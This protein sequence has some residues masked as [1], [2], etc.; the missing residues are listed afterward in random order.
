MSK[1]G[2]KS[3]VKKIYRYCRVKA[4]ILKKNCKHSVVNNDLRN[5]YKFNELSEFEILRETEKAVLI[6]A[7]GEIWIP[8]SA[9][10]EIFESK[11]DNIHRKSSIEWKQM[12]FTIEGLTNE[13]INE[14]IV[15]LTIEIKEMSKTIDIDEI[16]KSKEYKYLNFLKSRI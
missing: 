8:K 15:K 6:N 4:W 2:I 16:L 10:V 7:N 14:K 5:G 3:D 1:L 12:Y 9:L 13:E 11:F